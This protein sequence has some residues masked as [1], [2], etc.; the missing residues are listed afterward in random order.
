M[1]LT[2]I[3]DGMK[4]SKDDFFNRTYWDYHVL[5]WRS[6]KEKNDPNSKVEKIISQSE[7]RRYV[8]TL[9]ERSESDGGDEK[10]GN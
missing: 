8:E 1:K 7:A 3:L 10:N 2:E 9:P 6:A 4:E 5:V